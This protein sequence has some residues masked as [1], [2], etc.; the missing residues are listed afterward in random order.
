V[1]GEVTPGHKVYQRLEKVGF[2]YYT[3]EET[4]SLPGDPLDGFGFTPEIYITEE[5]RAALEPRHDKTWSFT[6]GM[7]GVALRLTFG[8]NS[9]TISICRASTRS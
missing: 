7:N 4:L 6:T 1:F 8:V 2:C 3:E 9:D 5:G